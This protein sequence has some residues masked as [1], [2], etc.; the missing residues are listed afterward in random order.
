MGISFGPTSQIGTER[1][2]SV[3]LVRCPLGFLTLVAC[4]RPI[5]YTW[6]SKDESALTYPRMCL[7]LLIQLKRCQ[8]GSEF[9]RQSKTDFL[10]CSS[11]PWFSVP[12]YTRTRE[13]VQA[14]VRYVLF[15]PFQQRHVQKVG[16][17]LHP[18]YPRD[19]DHAVLCCS[20]RRPGGE[21][22]D[23]HNDPHGIV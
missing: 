20:T 2:F 6:P 11:T 4:K 21:D 5:P 19:N 13:K 23:D 16:S 7:R 12:S 14:E 10:K 8:R 18:Q 15:L 1:G 17:E 9:K 3:E 22:S